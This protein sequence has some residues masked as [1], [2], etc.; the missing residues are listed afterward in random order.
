M[1]MSKCT[2]VV[3]GSAAFAVTT[4]TACGSPS[5]CPQSATTTVTTTV[6]STVAA[7]AAPPGP[8]VGKPS[9]TTAG[10]VTYLY[11]RFEAQHSIGPNGKP[12]DTT[13]AGT[14]YPS[15]TG[16]WVGCDGEIATTTYQLGG[17]YA[18]LHAVAGLQ[19]HA[20]DKLTVKVTIS[21]DDK[22]LQEF[23][24]GKSKTEPVDLDVTG[25]DELVVSAIAVDRS[26]CGVSGTPYGAFGTAVLTAN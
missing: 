24:V 7:A 10:A 5:G 9:T 3:M 6:I 25:V 11:E 20:P 15:S 1:R 12:V 22:P 19:P 13:L 4:L 14:P 17:Q 2:R 21:G 8:T 18:R 23:V 16:M 26:Q